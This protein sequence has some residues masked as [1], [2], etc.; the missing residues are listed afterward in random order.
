MQLKWLLIS[1]EGVLDRK[2]FW[3]AI[4]SL[5]FLSMILDEI[6]NSI[7]LDIGQDRISFFMFFLVKMIPRLLGILV[8]VFSFFIAKKRINDIGSS[9]WLPIIYVLSLF[10]PSFLLA[11]SQPNLFLISIIIP[12]IITFYL[13]LA[14][15]ANK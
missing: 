14:P 8:L 1:S 13:G 12:I 10:L 9:E 2:T 6:G 7:F 3:F 15:S 4:L 11:T 5:N